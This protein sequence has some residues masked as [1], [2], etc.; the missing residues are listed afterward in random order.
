ML[1]SDETSSVCLNAKLENMGKEMP[2]KV[3]A[4]THPCIMLL[5]IVKGM[6]VFTILV[7]YTLNIHVKLYDET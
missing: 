1:L 3:S 5:W 2:S 6:D 4:K 7:D